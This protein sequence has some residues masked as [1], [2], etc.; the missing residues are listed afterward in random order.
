MI[1]YMFD[2]EDDILLFDEMERRKQLPH[3]LMSFPRNEWKNI[4]DV[5]MSENDELFVFENEEIVVGVLW[6]IVH[7]NLLEVHSIFI[8]DEHFSDTLLMKLID[9][10]VKRAKY[11]DLKSITFPEKLSDE[12]CS[13]LDC[14]SLTY[15][16]SNVVCT[17]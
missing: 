5:R 6:F 11:S 16:G 3:L 8:K 2:P 1:Y 7:L 4:I 14:S 17:F 12:L 10:S 15:E 13:E 9:F